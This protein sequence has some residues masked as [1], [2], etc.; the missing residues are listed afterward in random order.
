M[1][2]TLGRLR[3][4]FRRAGPYTGVV[5]ACRQRPEAHFDEGEPEG[6]AMPRTWVLVLICGGVLLHGA[7]AA[8]GSPLNNTFAKLVRGDP[9]QIVV[10]GNSVTHGAPA[11]EERTTS[12]YW[13]LHDWLRERFPDAEIRLQTSIIFAIGPEL[14]LFRMESK[15]F[16]FTPDLVLA[17]FGAANGAWGESG[18]AVTD[19]ATEGYL[20]RLRTRLPE[21]DVVLQLG[22]FKSMLTHHEAGRTPPT[23]QFLQDLARHYGCLVAD[24]QQAI[25][26]RI[27]DGE[28][29]AAYMKDPIHPGPE[30]YAVHSRV[31]REALD[32]AYAAYR[33]DPRPVTPHKLPRKTLTARPWSSPRLV[34]ASAATEVTGFAP[35]DYGHFQGLEATGPVAEL[36]FQPERGRCVGLLVRRPRRMGRL[37]IR[38]D[39]AWAPLDLVH[40]P[41]AIEED[42]PG[43]NRLNR[44]FF[45]ADGLPLAWDRVAL[46]TELDA[47][48]EAV[49][50][51]GFL[52]VD[53]L[54]E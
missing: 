20:R 9:V 24:G 17:E 51:L 53:D 42:D 11:G 8:D 46:R 12:F 29:W 18:R 1:A 39:G 7:A 47:D 26:G 54:A 23:A 31:L 14:Q 44:H 2:L 32:R 6:E 25:A 13:A 50:L 3:L 36:V 5:S 35:A 49:Q 22:L 4:A 40:E 28:P 10:V 43:R 38:H 45:H 15:V 19:P 41:T 34:P 48:E 37:S 52:V 16:R 33:A 21:C 30:G 27:L